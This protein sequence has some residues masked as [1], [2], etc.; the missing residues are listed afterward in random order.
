MA[1][2]QGL[3][4]DRK[5]KLVLEDGGREWLDKKGYDPH[6]GA[7]PLKRVIQKSL[8]DRLAELILAGEVKDGDEVVV[9]ESDGHLTINGQ[10]S[11]VADHSLSPPPAPA[12]GDDQAPM[13]H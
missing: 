2:L 9:S 6:Y 13:L 3:L 8:Q 1:R 11:D 7:R 5:I 10:A 4:Q 12:A